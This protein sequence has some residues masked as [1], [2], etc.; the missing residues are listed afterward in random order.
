ML[1]QT[2]SHYRVVGSLGAGGMGVVYKAEDLK[3]SRFVALKFLAPD[4]TGD[5]HGVERFVREAQ[6]ASALNHPGIC[7]IYEIDEHEGRQFIAMELLE[8]LTLDR[9]IGGRPLEMALLLDLAIQITDALDAAHSRG[10]VHRDIKPANIFVTTRGLAKILDFGLAKLTTSR[11]RQADAQ[12][13]ATQL[14]T[15]QL[16]TMPGVALGTIAYMSP[17]QARGEEIDLRTDLFSFG[18]V[19]YE[20]AT[21]QRTFEGATSAV[22][23]D[24]ILNREPRAPTD[25]NA[26]IP[27]ALEQIIAKALEKDRRFRY[28]TAAD[29]GADLQ[30]IKRGRESR[31]VAA[32]SSSLPAASGSA[33]SRPS[34]P[35]TTIDSGASSAVGARRGTKSWSIALASF[36]AIALVGGAALFFVSR[37]AGTRIEVQ[38]AAV[39]GPSGTGPAPVPGAGLESAP[40]PPAAPPPAAPAQAGAPARPGTSTPPAAARPRPAATPAAAT[41]AADPVAQALKVARAKFDANLFDQALSDLNAAVAQTPSS[42]SAPAA[43]L[44][45]GA[46]QERQGRGDDAMATYVEL[47]TKHPSDAAAAEATFRQAELVLRSRR[48]DREAT[49]RSLFTDLVTAHPDSPWAPRALARKAALE[50]RSNQRV[51]DLQLATSVPV[52]LVS[53]RQLIDSYPNAENAEGALDKLAEM[54]EDLRRYELAAGALHDLSVRFPD[55][56]RDAAWRA[57]ELYEKRVKDLERARSSYALVPPR[58]SHYRDA[59]RKLQQ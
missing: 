1:G 18:V 32:R 5:A 48:N 23:F 52:A 28:Q 58:S 29:L 46:I 40:A 56:T 31:V 21:G 42:A 9:Q 27:P 10:I 47:R 54:Y 22:V 35:V 50:E 26:N 24:A 17:E 55:N 44:L 53:Y 43:Y 13:L 59:Q 57:G 49:A 51:V 37:D 14:P 36:G 25:L 12:D 8:G 7:T 41:T 19:L 3:L 38:P 6:T 11:G 39:P 15:E 4:L 34:G 45:I 20:M 30:R 2:I 16:T 33:A